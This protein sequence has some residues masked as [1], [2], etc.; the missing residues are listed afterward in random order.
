MTTVTMNLGNELRDLDLIDPVHHMLHIF[1]VKHPGKFAHLSEWLSNRINDGK[2]CG[3]GDMIALVFE[4]L[5]RGA[6]EREA[7]AFCMALDEVFM[8]VHR[9][10]GSPDTDLKMVSTKGKKES[11]TTRRQKSGQ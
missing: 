9:L 3:T 8:S 4:G 2:P 6:G 5:L 7:Q 1:L 10:Y 11:K